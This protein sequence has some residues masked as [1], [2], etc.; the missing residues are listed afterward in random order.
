MSVD[1]NKDQIIAKKEQEIQE[2]K[3]LLDKKNIAIIKERECT[4]GI[5]TQIAKVFWGYDTK[6]NS[7]IKVLVSKIDTNTPFTKQI[8][9]LLQ[10]QNLLLNES[11]KMNLF[12]GKLELYLTKIP[13]ALI[14]TDVIS[15]DLQNKASALISKQEKLSTTDLISTL[16]ELILETLPQIIKNASNNKDNVIPH[17]EMLELTRVIEGIELPNELDKELTIFQKSLRNQMSYSQAINILLKIIEIIN[18]STNCERLHLTNFLNGLNS[19]ISTIQAAINKNHNVTSSVVAAQKLN[20]EKFNT[21]L[22]E[23]NNTVPD[24]NIT[25]LSKSI[26]KRLH[27]INN[28]IYERNA[29]MQQQE[30]L[31]DQLND[32]ELRIGAVK[33]GAKTFNDGITE[34]TTRN[35]ID[36][37]T[38]LNNFYSFLNQLE[39][40]IKKLQLGTIKP[41]I[42]A[43]VNI[44]AFAK[45]NQQYDF[46]VGDKVLKVVALAL[47]RKIKNEDFIARLGSDHFGIISYDINENNAQ[48][49]FLGLI[50]TIRSI[51]FHYHNEKVQVTVSIYGCQIIGNIEPQNIISNL[52]EQFVRIKENKPNTHS[53]LIISQPQGKPI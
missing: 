19:Q 27:N 11:Q 36:N 33:E 31:L 30:K 48:Y 9:I 3:Q 5:I 28:L 44:D 8:D 16:S 7:E 29:F 40:D 42:T 2:L 32:I 13:N 50:R 6:F 4:I 17:K 38:G 43:I 47:K 23:I 12:I 45:I 1:L 37:L 35:L 10:L 46:N 49:Q 26:T 53:Q 41:F 24:T 15:P 34:L 52:E 14:Q 25:D 21:E 51:P 20:N 18:K 22:A 39:S